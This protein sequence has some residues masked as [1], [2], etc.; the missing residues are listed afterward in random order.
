MLNMILLQTSTNEFLKNPTLFVGMIIIITA[1]VSS[2]IAAFRLGWVKFNELNNQL[3]TEQ[4]NFMELYIQQNT[5]QTKV[6]EQNNS[7]MKQFDDS[8]KK[9]NQLSDENIEVT[10]D[11][12]K[13]I[14]TL[15]EIIENNFR[16]IN[17]H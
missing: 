2:L 15:N 10:K 7:V 14:K 1:L 9:N 13:S 16:K 6:L 8:L 11:L 17:S 4:K 3:L 12:M 5:A